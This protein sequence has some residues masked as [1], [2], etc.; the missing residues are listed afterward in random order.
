[1]PA[2]ELHA[3]EEQLKELGM[4]LDGM[5]DELKSAQ[6]TKGVVYRRAEYFKD[7]FDAVFA[8]IPS[9]RAYFGKELVEAM[10][11]FPKAR[12]RI[13]SSADMLYMVERRGRDEDDKFSINIRKDVFGSWGEE[14]EDSISTSL[15]D[16]ILKL[17][18]VLLPIIGRELENA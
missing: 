16:A 1:M 17:E 18:K 5:P 3:T 13:L 6:I 8:V 14:D 2:A 11:A 15:K 4:K 7:D 9:V 12:N 10:E